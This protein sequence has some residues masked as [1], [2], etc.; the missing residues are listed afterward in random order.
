MAAPHPRA[1]HGMDHRPG[2]GDADRYRPRRH[3]G[4]GCTQ[5]SHRSSASTAS[6]QRH[7]DRRSR[8]RST[9]SSRP[10]SWTPRRP[11]RPTDSATSLS[12]QAAWPSTTR[13]WTWASQERAACRSLRGVRGLGAGRH[14]LRRAAARA[15]HGAR[16]QVG[17]AQP[18]A[19]RVRRRGAGQPGHRAGTARPHPVD[20]ELVRC[21]RRRHRRGVPA[22]PQRRR[23]CRTGRRRRGAVE[24]AR[25]RRVRHHPRPIG[26]PQRPAGRG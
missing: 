21:R 2:A 20:R 13:S 18:G 4:T 15:L 14:R 6:I 25:F 12:P 11:G 17:G 1:A 24:P 22:H 26:G 3:S 16:H 23:R 10:T 8:P 19:G 9:I 5:A 7:S